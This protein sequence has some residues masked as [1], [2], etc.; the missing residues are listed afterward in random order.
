[1]FPKEK[2]NV[3]SFFS[4]SLA[5]CDFPGWNPG[6]FNTVAAIIR[7]TTIAI[8]IIA[9]LTA[10]SSNSISRAI[11]SEPEDKQIHFSILHTNDEHSALIPH[12][13]AID[14]HPEKENPARGGM[15]RLAY[16][17]N[18]IKEE[19][20][21]IDE[22][23]MLVNAG[24]FMGGTIYNWLVFDGYAPELDLLQQIGFDLVAIGN[25][26]FDHGPDLLADY[27]KTAGHPDAGENTT[28]LATNTVIPD[29]HPLENVGIEKTHVKKLDP[30]PK[31]GF[32]S[33]MGYDAMRVI[34]ESGPV[35]FMDPHKSAREAISF[36]REEKEV[37]LVVAVN[38]SGITEDRELAEDV[39]GIDII[40]G[41][42]SHTAMEKPEII[43]DT[44][45]VQAGAHLEYLGILELTYN[46][47]SGEVRPRNEVTG[48]PY[49]I[50]LDHTVPQ[51]PEIASSVDKF[52]EKL[53]RMIYELTGGNFK[54]ILEPFATSEFKLP[55]QPYNS[56]NQLGNLVTDA[57]RLVVEEKTGE[58]VDFA[59]Q[60][61]GIIR[62]EL[63]PGSADH[64]R[65]LISIYDVTEAVAIGSGPAGT[66][67]FPLASAYLTGEEIKDI[68]EISPLASQYMGDN[69]FLQV[70][71]LRYAYYPERL[72]LF[73]IPGIDLPF[74]S[75][76]AVSNV[77]KYTEEGP[78]TAKDED[79][80]SL[81][82]DDEKLYHI[83]TDYILLERAVPEANS[84]IPWL[85][86]EPKDSDGKPIENFEDCIVRVDGEDF[87]VW[88]TVLEY[89]DA[90]PQTDNS[91]ELPQIDPYYEET[92]GRINTE[93]NT[94]PLTWI[95]V[96]LATLYTISPWLYLLPAAI[97]F[98]IVFK[99]TRRRIRKQSH[100]NN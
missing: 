92:M 68:L 57:M 15:A 88:E 89:I 80:A 96:Y 56:E 2:T 98:G 16:K 44:L 100:K 14:H 77:E 65:D 30:G 11:A 52:T 85:S 62:S 59:F 54:D 46:P 58:E 79:F 72:I 86:I 33:L 53:E 78:Q 61:S 42:H 5:G 28:L 99:L 95:G 37:D 51:D 1:M 39:S 50:P 18:R 26:E 48:T 76:Q 49:L 45:I 82:I 8:V 55:N 13:T 6:L 27:L 43:E 36:L 19:K 73:H 97:I 17:V 38:H 84:L 67:G 69:Y 87:K 64:S 7:V 29:D 34:V 10:I 4:F 24:D 41:G 47:E 20:E 25:H 31:I 63:V 35:D 32:F 75:F 93:S 9:V 81:E 94:G 91:S 83:V 12:G 3:H 60:G 74:P 66:P 22:E 23:V 70:S 90:Q 21:A 40:V 71:G